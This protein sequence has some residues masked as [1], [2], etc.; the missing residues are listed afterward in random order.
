MSSAFTIGCTNSAEAS[1]EAST[2]FQAVL[3]ASLSLLGR[4]AVKKGTALE[5]T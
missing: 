2:A 5:A 1:A 3:T 4:R